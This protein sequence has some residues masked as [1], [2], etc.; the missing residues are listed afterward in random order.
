[1]AG[2]EGTTVAT[3]SQLPGTMNLA[4]RRGDEFGSTIDFDIS[5]VGYAVSA[6]ITST[7][8]GQD[9][10]SITATVTN[11]AAGVV[12]LAMTEAETGGLAA[13][14]YGWRLEWVAPGD[15]KRTALTGFAEVTA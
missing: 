11:E 10:R 2:L 7:V 3:Y 5:M 8:T 9:I 13:G 14:T 1:M 15:V 6:A 12:A 4:F